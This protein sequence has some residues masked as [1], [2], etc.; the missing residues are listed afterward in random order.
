MLD[1]SQPDPLIEE[2][3]E[4][5]YELNEQQAEEYEAY[6]QIIITAEQTQEYLE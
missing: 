6:Q 1:L 3:L 4:E 2:I 5:Y